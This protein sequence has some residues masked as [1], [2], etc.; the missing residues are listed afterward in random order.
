MPFEFP[1]GSINIFSGSLIFIDGYDKKKNLIHRKPL[2]HVTRNIF[3]L[4]VYFIVHLYKQTA[5]IN[6]MSFNGQIWHQ[7]SNETLILL[8]TVFFLQEMELLHCRHMINDQ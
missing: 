3:T 5:L 4:P 6:V 7:A 8:K 2:E 1:F